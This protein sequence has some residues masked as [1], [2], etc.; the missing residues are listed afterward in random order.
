MR[1]LILSRS[2]VD[3]LLDMKSVLTAVEGAYREKGEGTVQMPPK[4][5]LFYPKYNGDL[6]TMPSYL[7]GLDKTGVKIVNVHPDNP[8]KH[9]IPSVMA[10]IVLVEPATGAPLSIM[11][12]T[13]IT[14]FRTGAGCGIAT[15]Y[16]SRKDSTTLA[17][18]GAGVQAYSQLAAINEVREVEKLK[19]YD[20]DAQRVDALINRAEKAFPLDFIKCD[21]VRSCVQDSDIISTQTPVRKPIVKEEWISPGTHINAVGADAPGKEELEPALL[22]K[23]K[24]IID[25]WAQASHSGEINVPLSRGLIRREDVY[26]E[27]GEIVAGKKKG[28]ASKDE[29]TIFDTTGLSIQ[30]VATA[31]LVYERATRESVGLY[32]DF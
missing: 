32:I 8:K 25:D 12:G 19:V 15:R 7:S 14:A 4:Q 22:K 17:L 2:E 16:L 21:D 13:G 5:Y 26:G 30:D 31:T 1:T 27:I 3:S 28:R 24:I 11:D 10:V 29:I 6:R 20:V 9:H 18:V 23:S